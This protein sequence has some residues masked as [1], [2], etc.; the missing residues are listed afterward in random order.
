MKVHR[1]PVVTR[2]QRC[3]A[4]EETGEKEG[5]RDRT[6]MRMYMC[7]YEREREEGKRGSE[8][9]GRFYSL[10]DPSSVSDL[11][12]ERSLFRSSRDRPRSEDKLRGVAAR[13]NFASLLE[14]PRDVYPRV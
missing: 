9:E 3:S 8:K 7:V 10:I 1:V 2:L 12:T 6:I 13:F 14:D 4:R 11:D 5:A